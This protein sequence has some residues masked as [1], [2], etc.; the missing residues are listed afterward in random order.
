MNFNIDSDAMSHICLRKEWAHWKQHQ[1]L[2]M[3]ISTFLEFQGIGNIWGKTTNS[4]HIYLKYV[5]FVTILNGQFISLKNVEANRYYVIFKHEELPTKKDN[6]R[7]LLNRR[8]NCCP[9][10]CNFLPQSEIALT[11]NTDVNF[12]WHIKCAH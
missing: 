10:V 7:L 5:H 9:Y 4:C 8:K 12:L 3:W 6:K 1:E 2:L 11:S